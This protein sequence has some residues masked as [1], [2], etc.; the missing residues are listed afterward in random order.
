MTYK[1]KDILKAIG[2]FFVLFSILSAFMLINGL[3]YGGVL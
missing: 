1:F 3:H 2:G